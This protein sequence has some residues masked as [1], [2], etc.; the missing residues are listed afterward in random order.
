MGSIKRYIVEVV[1]T[2]LPKSLPIMYLFVPH[3]P[4]KAWIEL[5]L[6]LAVVRAMSA[7][8]GAEGVLDSSAGIIGEH[9]RVDVINDP[10]M[11]HMGFSTVGRSTSEVVERSPSLGEVTEVRVLRVAEREGHFP[12]SIDRPLL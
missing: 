3:L 4:A 1:A 6:V 5:T 2:A 7:S 9:R 8:G 12:W 11:Q 10:A